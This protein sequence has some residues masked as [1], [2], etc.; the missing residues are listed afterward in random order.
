MLF[1]H[2]IKKGDREFYYGDYSDDMGSCFLDF[3]VVETGEPYNSVHVCS[4][5]ID[6]C[7][8]YA[9]KVGDIRDDKEWQQKLEDDLWEFFHK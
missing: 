7:N 4:C 8:D 9:P 5:M 3:H 1:I 2:P 6:W